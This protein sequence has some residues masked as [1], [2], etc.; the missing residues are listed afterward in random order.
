MKTV[1]GNIWDYY[2]AGD[3]NFVCI[4]TNGILNKHGKLVMGAGLALQ[5]K[6]RIKDID[7][8]FGMHVL[9]NG[10]VPCFLIE[11]GVI[12][13]PT[14]DHWINKS[15]IS[16]IK[17]SCEYINTKL[18]GFRDK[19]IIEKIFIPKVGCENGKLDWNIVKPILEFYFGNDDRFVLVI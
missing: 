11:H 16:L 19:K 7:T 13:F 8:K 18:K 9:K 3:K 17:N 15:D 2:I 5:A 6:K 10:N 4:T 12:S 1:S 14:K